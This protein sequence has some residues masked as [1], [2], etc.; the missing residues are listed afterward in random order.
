MAPVSSFEDIVNLKLP[1][2]HTGEFA[3]EMVQLQAQIAV[4]NMAPEILLLGLPHFPGASKCALA[5]LWSNWRQSDGMTSFS[6]SRQEI[7]LHIVSYIPWIDFFPHSL[8]PKTYMHAVHN[9]L[10][11]LFLC[12]TLRTYLSHTLVSSLSESDL[13]GT[14]VFVLINCNFCVSSN[15]V[16]K[17]TVQLG[18]TPICVTLVS[19][20]SKSNWTALSRSCW[21][22]VVHIVSS[23]TLQLCYVYINTHS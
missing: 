9:L 22:I 6:W 15:S 23:T 13:D 20:P 14:V 19:S 4:A 18:R 12:C 1:S 3:L 2:S 8:H 16:C 21:S 10:H 7:L 17:G 11:T 5:L